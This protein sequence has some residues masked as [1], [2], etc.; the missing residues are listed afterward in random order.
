MSP[1]EASREIAQEHADSLGEIVN[2]F[3]VFDGESEFSVLPA[4]RSAFAAALAPIARDV[5]S[6]VFARTP[7]G[8]SKIQQMGML[9]TSGQFT[10]TLVDVGIGRSEFAVAALKLAE[11]S[12]ASRN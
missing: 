11:P 4:D 12:T 10:R 3:V 6:A 7:L 8:L 9:L 1:L 2:R 5:A